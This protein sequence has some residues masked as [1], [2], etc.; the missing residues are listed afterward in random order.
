MTSPSWELI[1]SDQSLPTV[2]LSPLR[3]ILIVSQNSF[4]LCHLCPFNAIFF[5]NRCSL[6]PWYTCQLE[7]LQARHLQ[8]IT[9][10]L[11][12]NGVDIIHSF[13]IR[14]IFP[15][16]VLCTRGYLADTHVNVTVSS[17]TYKVQYKQVQKHRGGRRD[18]MKERQQIHIPLTQKHLHRDVLRV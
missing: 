5:T 7:N 15:S 10:R 9:E 18:W 13:F 11:F 17:F 14:L 16:C 2:N 1:E 6:S 12:A 4:S 3:D 8:L